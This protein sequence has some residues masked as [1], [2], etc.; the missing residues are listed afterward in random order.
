[1]RGSFSSAVEPTVV[2]TASDVRRRGFEAFGKPNF[3]QKS[4]TF[5][6]HDV[7][8]QCKDPRV[9]RLNGRPTKA[10]TYKGVT[11]GESVSESGVPS[12]GER[13]VRCRV[14][15]PCLRYRRAKWTDVALAEIESAS[16]VWF[17]T[18]TVGPREW[19]LASMAVR[20][21]L[22]GK[23]PAGEW[24]DWQDW[25]RAKMFRLW[26][27]HLYKEVQSWFMR[28]RRGGWF[29]RTRRLDDGS[30]LD[31]WSFQ[32]RGARFRYV[33]VAEP[34]KTGIPHFHLLL[35][36][37][38]EPLRKAFLESR[39]WIGHSAAKL[40]PAGRENRHV[41]GYV[42]KYLSKELSSRVWASG[43]REVE[44]SAVRVA[45]RASGPVL[46]SLRS[47][48]LEQTFFAEGGASAPPLNSFGAVSSAA[49]GCQADEPPSNDDT[50]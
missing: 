26:S 49:D 19:Q 2:S 9:V 32:E 18:L 14:C 46:T 41:A 5:W 10:V 35:C 22:E 34:H 24:P 44:G 30:F 4:V 1:M 29:C 33:C 50:T 40:V 43:T 37:Q 25:Q 42:C 11:L 3:R 27:Q 16:R 15:G 12:H 20:R 17:V 39:W 8:G 38:E 36:E 47:F 28:L 48:D 13:T 7:A 21:D 23:H 6:Q 45:A 31:E